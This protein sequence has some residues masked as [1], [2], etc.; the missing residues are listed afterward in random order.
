MLTA[1]PTCFPARPCAPVCYFLHAAL[2]CWLQA[3]KWLSTDDYVMLDSPMSH[4]HTMEHSTDKPAVLQYQH[5]Q[6]Q[7]QEQQCAA[8]ASPLAS[9]RRLPEQRAGAS[10][11]SCSQGFF[12]EPGYGRYGVHASSCS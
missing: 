9:G 6:Q 10:G 7:Q 11:R 4:Q 2:C 1:V 3:N 8:T 12:T 5:Q